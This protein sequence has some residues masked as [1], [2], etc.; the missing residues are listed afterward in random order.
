MANKQTH[1][2][3]SRPPRITAAPGTDK[4]SPLFRFSKPGFKKYVWLTREDLY[5]MQNQLQSLEDE[6][7]L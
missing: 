6:G 5:A 3:P 2:I 4:E 7:L 1:N